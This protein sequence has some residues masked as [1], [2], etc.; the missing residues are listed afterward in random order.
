MGNNANCSCNRELAPAFIPEPVNP[1]L[2]TYDAAN[3]QLAFGTS[4]QTFD[5][6]GNRLTRTDSSGTL[7][8]TWDA[9][10]RLTALTGPSLIASFAYDGLGRRAQKTV[11]SVLTQFRYDGLD[12]VKESSGGSDVAYL[13]TLDIDEALVRTDAV[14]STHYLADALGSSVALTN[15]GGT[16]AT[17]YTY[18]PFG[19][20]TTAG[21]PSPNPFRFTGREDDG[22]GLY[23]YRARY[24]DP[25]RSR[26]VSED[27]IRL[28]VPWANAFRYA[29]N[30]PI[31]WVDP[32]GLWDRRTTDI[33]RASAA[34]LGVVSGVAVITSTAPVSVPA[35]AIAAS[36]TAYGEWAYLKALRDLWRHESG[37]SCPGADRGVAEDVLGTLFGETGGSVGWGV[38]LG[39][40]G[41]SAGSSALGAVSA[42]RTAA[43][44]AGRVPLPAAQGAGYGAL[45][46]IGGLLAP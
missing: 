14:D 35:L 45:S 22:T 24:Y 41:L 42:A 26:F 6:T 3:R 7:T 19:E 43:Q 34:A 13:R 38:D 30:N 11:N 39:V 32:Y 23:Y 20:T 25:S 5:D 8:Y 33:I 18:A 12:A 44:N 1:F 46:T 31:A 16:T 4:T 40:A 10:N 21:P 29:T 15:A 2:L 17:T 27:P 9:R 36:L 37:A 28:L